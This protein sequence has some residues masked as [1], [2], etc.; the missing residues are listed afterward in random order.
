MRPTLSPWAPH[1][2]RIAH[3][4]LGMY[5]PSPV[6]ITLGAD[7]FTS[8]LFNIPLGTQAVAAA[9]SSADWT[10]EEQKA[11]LKAIGI[12][13]VD[14]GFADSA[15]VDGQVLYGKAGLATFAIKAYG[16]T[17][18]LVDKNGNTVR[19]STTPGDQTLP[20]VDISKIKVTVL[21]SRPN[22]EP[23]PSPK[24]DVP[25]PPG[26]ST[27]NSPT[28]GPVLGPDGKPTQLFSWLPKGFTSL[29]DILKWLAIAAAFGLTLYT[30]DFA[31][32]D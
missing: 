10:P 6:A 16:K 12:A 31:T 29:T 28:P 14:Q 27:E 5:E 3:P 8:G 7:P 20:Y 15:G 24:I 1:A 25:S 26:G 32:K 17:G 2:P 19:Y 18:H 11:L 4:Y 9:T 30:V 21:P 13:M 23:P 22:A